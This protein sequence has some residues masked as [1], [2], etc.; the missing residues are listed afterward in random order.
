MERNKSA[1][2]HCC[3][4]FFLFIPILSIVGCRQSG[5]PENVLRVSKAV[6]RLL[7]TLRHDHV[8]LQL[9]GPR[10]L[11]ATTTLLYI[12]KSAPFHVH[13]PGLSHLVCQQRLCM[14]LSQSVS[15]SVK[16]V[17]RLCL[18][19]SFT[20]FN[21]HLCVTHSSPILKLKNRN[22]FQ[23][24]IVNFQDLKTPSFRGRLLNKFLLY[25]L[26]LQAVP[27]HE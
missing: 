9:A 13:H 22:R 6:Y 7:K 10:H 12:P 5:T 17:H 3:R 26:V 15:Q 27:L 11:P 18:F 2:L 4:F 19:L 16:S 24:N 1:V 8:H 14:T 23:I 21:K 20:P 25:L